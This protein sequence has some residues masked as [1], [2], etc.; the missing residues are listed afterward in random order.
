LLRW[1]KPR[2]KQRVARK[3]PVINIKAPDEV[4]L[5][6]I[7]GIRVADG[8]NRVAGN[9]RLYRDL[10]G[11]FAA[12]QGDASAQISTALESGDFKLAERIAHTV[13]GV[14]GNLGIP[15]VQ[16][17][18][19]KLEKALRDGE[20]TVSE[21]LVEFAR[22]MGTQVQAID[23][24]LR[25]SATTPQETEQPSVF[26][27]EAAA[28]AITQLRNLLKTSDGNSEGAFRCLKDIVAGVVE[29]TNLD[30]LGESINDFD[31]DSALVKLEA[32]ALRCA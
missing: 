22:I 13:K 5:P 24:V 2:P 12:K 32:I 17:A 14:A 11:Q 8:L 7:S 20:G 15:G 3:T 10:L 16:S 6:E 31:F 29:H 23:D 25:D 9:T 28:A 30:S 21:L 19:Q 26:D 27:K 18:A 1:A 4:A